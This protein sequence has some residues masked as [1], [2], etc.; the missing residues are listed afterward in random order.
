MSSAFEPMIQI[1]VPLWAI[2]TSQFNLHIASIF[3][4]ENGYQK[5]YAPIQRMSLIQFSCWILKLHSPYSFVVRHRN[6]SCI[7]HEHN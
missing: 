3:P 4:N 1:K 2:P 7:E 5:S 6:L